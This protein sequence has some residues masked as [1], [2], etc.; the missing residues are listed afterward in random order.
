[1]KLWNNIWEALNTEIQIPW[2]R[3]T[4]GGVQGGQAVLALAKA[5]NKKKSESELKPLIEQIDSLLDI[6][7]SPLVEVAG[8]ALPFI[9]IATDLLQFLLEKTRQEPTLEDSVALVSQ[10][11]Y[12]ESLRQFLQKHPEIAEKLEHI[13]ASKAVENQI[14][15]LGK[16]LKLNG[17]EVE[18]DDRSARKVLLCFRNSALAEVFNLILAERLKESGLE[19]EAAATVAKRV[20]Y[21]THR[22]MKEAL[23]TAGEA[24]KNLAA[25]YGE[26]W[27]RDQE[28]YLSIEKYLEEEIAAKPRERVFDEEF[29]FRDIYIPLEV[30]PVT[31]DGK[32]SKKAKP[33]NIEQWALTWLLEETD[34]KEV[35]FIQGG[36]GRGKSVFC[37]MFADW[38]RQNLHPI[39]TPILIRLR[40]V[41]AFEL[42]FDKTL[43][44][45]VARDFVTS[46]SGWLT[47]PNTRFLFLLDGFDELLMERGAGLDLQQFLEQVAL[48][49]QR[50]AVNDERGHR[51]LITGRPLSLYGIERTMPDNLKR[52]G[53]IEI[54]PE[55]QQ[56]WFAKWQGVVAADPLDAETKTLAFRKFLD[57][58]RCPK[59]VG[60]LAKEPLLLYLLA[61]MHRDGQLRAE[62]FQE[63]D[64]AEAK[65]Q[66]YEAA[67]EWVLE[68]QRGRK[69]TRQLTKLDSE[70]LRSVLAEA[71]LCVAQSGNER[72]LVKF[73]ED[74]L[75]E[76]GEPA[77][78]ELIETARNISAKESPLK[79][80]L[81][82]F[83]VKSASASENAVEFFH[84]SFGEFLCALRLTESLIDWTQEKTVKRRVSYEVRIPEFQ[85]Q[86]YDL[87]GYGH[88][89]PEIIEYLMALLKRKSDFGCQLWQNLLDRLYDFYLSW[90]DGEFIEF[91]TDL[92]EAV[93]LPLKK[94]SQLRQY[95]IQR[96]QRQADI[97]AGLN[98]LILL[99][100]INRYGKQAGLADTI[101]FYPCGKKGDKDF[102]PSRLLKAIGYSESLGWGTFARELGLFLS[103]ANLNGAYLS[104]AYLEGACLNSANLSGAY[105]DG[106]YLEGAYLPSGNLDGAY[107]EGA[108]LQRANLKG[109]SLAG[110][111]LSG[112]YL[113]NAKLSSANLEG[114]NLSGANLTSANLEGAKLE[115]AN[116]SGANL[117]SANFSGASLDRAN[118]EGANLNGARFDRNLLNGAGL[119]NNDLDNNGSNGAGSD[120][121]GSGDRKVSFK[122]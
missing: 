90:C 9:S 12:L 32:V 94:A 92:K 28:A 41:Q 40:D 58:K 48:F 64:K 24:L 45:A 115:G 86:V 2:A 102:E 85:W 35:L 44:A 108:Y 80:A 42:D 39:W 79:N 54:S 59:E 18:L 19:Q 106:A 107:L 10:A 20:A 71:G 98:A 36:P 69:L 61:A 25:I 56:K 51:L 37:R 73:I 103:F 50:S 75:L 60:E 65:V 112:A 17:R 101:A 49:Q 29:T 8:A 26:G 111:N 105:L 114:A 46:D 120:S 21:D 38:V 57:D 53:I 82:A 93:T 99:L 7:N 66:I 109:A 91:P 5:L 70:D 1:M 83:Y 11:A 116:L 6:L 84:K 52:G 33:Q 72:A 27:Q 14:K 63:A 76:K 47:D 15:N 30:K 121:N 117:E 95:K 3:V 113:S 68:K 89:S 4:K 118:L 81:A 16:N 100:E 88:I 78:R 34:S 67:L 104:G 74:R 122:L 13:P 62:N 119:D 97:Y 87:L 96:G 77:A 22:Y 23:T 31:K 110:A 43:S 55:N